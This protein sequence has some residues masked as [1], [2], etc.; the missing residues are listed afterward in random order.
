MRPFEERIEKIKQEIA[1][2]KVVPWE[3]IA[4]LEEKYELV[5]KHNTF[6]AIIQLVDKICRENDIKYSIAYGTLMG[7]VRHKNFIPW[8]DDA[9]VMMTRGEFV[10]FKEA[11]EKYP[12]IMLFKILF[13]DRFSTKELFEKGIYIDIF[14]FDYA[15]SSKNERKKIVFL[16]KIYRMSF[17]SW[18]TYAEKV[19]KKKGIKKIIFFFAYLCCMIIGSLV[20]LFMRKNLI[21]KHE[22]LI[23]KNRE[24]DSDY[25]VSYTGTWDDLNRDYRADWFSA[26]SEIE[27]CGNKFMAIER[28]ED[29]FINRYGDYITLPPEDSRKP[30]H[31]IGIKERKDWQILL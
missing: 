10:K 16:S 7:A 22:K 8:D 15:P 14:V 30:E 25:M 24:V 19:K 4:Y 13:T 20:K 17:F 29:F 2:S 31:E 23:T 1:G 3:E 11:V 6:I 5:E 9:D 26:Y 21:L 18:T 28:P 27:L 12:D